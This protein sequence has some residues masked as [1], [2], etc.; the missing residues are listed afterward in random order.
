VVPLLLEAAEGCLQL[1][2]PEEVVGLLEVRA[3]RHD[4]VDKVLN[5]DDIVL[6]EALT[7]TESKTKTL[8]IQG[9]N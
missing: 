1:E 9:W 7:R 5:A 3:H 4:L 8:F 6:P 2:R